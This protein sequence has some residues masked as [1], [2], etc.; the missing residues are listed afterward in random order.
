MAEKETELKLMDEESSSYVMM[1][2][3]ASNDTDSIVE[4]NGEQLLD[5]TKLFMIAHARQQ[6]NRI[7]KLTKFLEKLEDKFIDAVNNRLDNEPESITMISMAM[8]TIS[9]C[10]ESAN[11]EVFQILKDDRLANIV[12]NTTNII[13][14]DGNSATIIDAD[15]RDEVRNL[16][17]SLLQQLTNISNQAEKQNSDEAVI[18]VETTEETNQEEKDDTNV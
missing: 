15:S 14:P 8:E 9:K 5:R 2:Q 11:G 16:A 3:L 12:I 7:I 18:D 1:H 4:I 13:T 17:S 10:L 6:L